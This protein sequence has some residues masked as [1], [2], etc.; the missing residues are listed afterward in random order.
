MNTTN[1]PLR[2]RTSVPRALAGALQ[3]LPLLGLASAWPAERSELDAEE[4]LVAATSQRLADEELVLAHAVEVAGVEDV[5]AALERLVDGRDALGLVRCPV[6]GHEDA[7]PS[8]SVGTEPG[9]GWCC[10]AAGCGAR[11][12]IYDLASALAGGPWGPALRGEA[13]TRARARVRAA[14]G[15]APGVRDEPQSARRAVPPCR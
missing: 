3:W 12:T 5:H 8:C 4:R 6:P 10:H 9:Q 15:D 2:A 13:F 1:R 11:G 14:F 7:H